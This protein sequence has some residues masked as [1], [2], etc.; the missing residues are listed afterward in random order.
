MSRQGTVCT[1]DSINANDIGQ[2]SGT[3]TVG[4]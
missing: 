1:V 2:L 3:G 4:T